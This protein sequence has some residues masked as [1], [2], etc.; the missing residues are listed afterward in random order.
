MRYLFLCLF[1]LSI[2]VAG[3]NKGP[4]TGWE[5][6]DC[7]WGVSRSAKACP[8][9]GADLERFSARERG[10]KVDRFMNIPPKDADAINAEEKYNGR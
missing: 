6:P 1:V 8:N 9:C 10:K 7:D 5:C 4:N 3:C 2:C